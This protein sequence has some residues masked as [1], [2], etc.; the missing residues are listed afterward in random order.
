MTQFYSYDPE[1]G[2]EIHDTAEQAKA[3]A[4][5]LMQIYEDCAP[6]DGWHEDQEALCWGELK[7]IE[8]AQVTKR[9]PGNP[10]DG[11][12]FD[13]YLEYALLPSATT[14]NV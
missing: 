4:Q 1:E 7:Q 6:S 13:E 9:R 8:N 14:P 3:A 11:E 5:A 2:F 12:E 10:D